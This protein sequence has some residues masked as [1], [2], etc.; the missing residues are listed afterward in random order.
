MKSPTME[1]NGRGGQR[2]AKGLDQQ[3]Q[4]M[5]IDACLLISNL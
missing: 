2:Q 3:I 5:D 1:A 4:S